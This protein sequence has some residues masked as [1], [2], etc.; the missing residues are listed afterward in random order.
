MDFQGRA[1]HSADPHDV[2][3]PQSA[4]P[5]LGHLAA[6]TQAHAD[7]RNVEL[8]AGGMEIHPQNMR[9]GWYG[10]ARPNGAIG[11]CAYGK[12]YH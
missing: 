9:F 6:I 8:L 4:A 5:S 2:S 12:D 7:G 10:H 11:A 1:Y 3:L